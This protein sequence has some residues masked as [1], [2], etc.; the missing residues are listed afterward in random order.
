M[1][2]RRCLPDRLDDD[3]GSFDAKIPVRKSKAHPFPGGRGLERAID[4]P[5]VFK[6][7][8]SQKTAADLATSVEEAHADERLLQGHHR[9][10]LR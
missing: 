1:Q 2:K 6:P 3:A 7:G 4:G 5:S 8:R 10:F 9:S